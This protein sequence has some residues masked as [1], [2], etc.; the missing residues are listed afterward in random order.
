MSEVTNT[1]N[2]TNETKE[3]KVFD[4]SYVDCNQCQNYWN[5]SCDGTPTHQIRPC[6]AF[7]ATRHTDIPLQL[8]RLSMKLKQSERHI[9]W[10]NLILLLHLLLEFLVAIGVIK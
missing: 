2:T 4:E 3:T 10:V 9:L 5:D 8:E 1:T 7:K 6:T